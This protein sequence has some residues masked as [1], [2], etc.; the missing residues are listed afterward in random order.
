MT[1]WPGTSLTGVSGPVNTGPGALHY[2]VHP[3]RQEES[4]LHRDPRLVA[5]GELLWLDQRFV[6]PGFLGTARQVLRDR[7]VVLLSGAPGTGT[8]SAAK[9]LL[10][11][12]GKEDRRFHELSTTSEDGKR[13]GLDAGAVADHDR[14]LLDLTNITA[15]TLATVQSELPAFLG[16]VQRHRAHLAVVLPPHARRSLP[17]ELKWHLVELDRPRA[18]PV[19]RRHLRAFG[20][21]PTDDEVAS[22]Q[23]A[24]HLAD[25]AMR[26]IAD[27]ADLFQRAK[28]RNPR[29]GFAQW[30]EMALSAWQDRAEG[31][32]KLVARCTS[33]P[34]RA[35]LLATGML[36]GARADALH[37]AT[38]MLLR[39]AHQPDD[40]TV[41]LERPGLVQR[42]AEVEA[43]PDRDGRV[44]FDTLNLAPEVRKFFWDNHPSL[45]PV[46]EKWVGECLSV[47]TLDPADRE[48]LVRR[49]AE[50]ALR[51][52]SPDTLLSLVERWSAGTEHDV[53]RR[54]AAGTALAATL[55]DHRYGSETRRRIYD[56]S[57]RPDLPVGLAT[58][59]IQVCSEV[60]AVHHP[61]Q[62]M[63]RLHHLARQQ[64]RTSG[65]ARRALISLTSTD[66]R[67][68]RR[69]L[70]RVTDK[71]ATPHTWDE[72]LFLELADPV[73][74]AGTI[75]RTQPFLVDASVRGQLTFC[76]A[77]V[78]AHRAPP[79]WRATA[80][81]W[82]D[83]CHEHRHIDGRSADLL[84]DVL[85][86]AGGRR[87]DLA[88]RLYVTA[89]DWADAPGD[90]RTSERPGGLKHPSRN[91]RPS[92]VALADRLW[93]KLDKAGS[94]PAHRP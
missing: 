65:D 70:S 40:E 7:N 91:D 31:V 59:L 23:L 79:D 19:F 66:N 41:P 45:R 25:A 22:P 8:A 27:L 42:L 36:H 77:A 20:I 94:G 48:R 51:T 83:A 89:L 32:A 39:A 60:L 88:A 73:R 56:W 80:L 38:I 61:D 29:S 86:V 68:F 34:Q 21:I 17:P 82:L 92:R 93:R 75:D 14:L 71:L 15:S 16:G 81:R 33:G 67:L 76:W 55:A 72:D 6:A 43:T 47:R 10:H 57:V 26:D 35:L 64:S 28:E 30:R 11:E 62:A 87:R 44:T 3:P 2:H 12:L 37:N 84:L 53:V 50:H 5:E 18:M 85:A 78:L 49:F 46:F 1:V 74:L 90:D 24:A 9:I 13:D 4:T 63:V 54:H 69:L 58:V 52:E